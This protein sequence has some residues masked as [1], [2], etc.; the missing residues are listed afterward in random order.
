MIL[1]ILNATYPQ[2]TNVSFDIK[3][4]ATPLFNISLYKNESLILT[5]ITHLK[6]H[7]FSLDAG[8]YLLTVDYP[9]D[10][11][12][13]E[14]SK[15]ITF[16]VSKA[17]TKINLSQIA[18]TVYGSDININYTLS[19][20]GNVT[21]R[22]YKN[23]KLMTTKISNTSETLKI[24]DSAFYR[25]E[26]DY[27]GDANHMKASQYSNFTVAQASSAIVVDSYSNIT[28]LENFNIKVTLINGSSGSYQ[29]YKDNKVV[30]RGIISS[31]ISV[32]GLEVGD[33]SIV[34]NN[35]GNSNHESSSLTLPF[36]V[37]K[38]TPTITIP[39]ISNRVYGNTVPVSFSI[40]NNQNGEFNVS[41]Y[42]SNVLITSKLINST[43]CEF[44]SL[45]SGNYR[46]SVT[47]LGDDNYNPCTK[48]ASFNVL[49]ASSSVKIRLM[50]SLVYGFNSYASFKVVNG[51][52]TY[53]VVHAGSVIK[54]GSLSKPV[55]LSDLNAGTY[56]INAYN[57]GDANHLSSTDSFTFTLR[58]ATPKLTLNSIDDLN[59]LDN[60]TVS[61]T[62]DNNLNSPVNVT[63]IKDNVLIESRLING[64]ETTFNYLNAGDYVVK[65]TYP[66]DENHMDVTQSLN[67]AVDKSTSSVSLTGVSNITYG[68]V[69]K[70]NVDYTNSTSLN[71]ILISDKN[72]TGNASDVLEFNNLAGGDYIVNVFNNG[73]ENHRP[74]SCT[75]KFSVLKADS[76]FSVNLIPNM[77]WNEILNITYAISGRATGHV[78]LTLNDIERTY[79]LF[80]EISFNDL[81]SGQY[82]LTLTYSGD[83]N[84]TSA[85]QIT[86]FEIKPVVSYVF[87]NTDKKCEITSTGH[88]YTLIYNGKT[89][90]VNVYP[91][92]I[93]VNG[94]LYAGISNLMIDNYEMGLLV[95]IQA[96]IDDNYNGS[97]ASD[98]IRVNTYGVYQ[99]SQYDT[100][101]TLIL[102]SDASGSGVVS[103]NGI[104]YAFDI[105]GGVGG[106]NIAGLAD[107]VYTYTLTYYGDVKY[108]S[109][110]VHGSLTVYHP[111]VKVKP[112]LVAS[113][114]TYKASLK[115]KKY[116]VT[117]KGMS[118][119]KLT[120]KINKKTYK[121]KTNSK[122]KA[123]FKIRLKKEGSYKAKI[124]YNGDKYHESV[125]KTVRIIIKK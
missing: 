20:D 42:K 41:V 49:K 18:D 75:A 115:V 19:A 76:G 120:L 5:N 74:S 84:F 71:Y 118:K 107:G 93:F 12:Y 80:E 57:N 59:Y 15:N 34:L 66:G 33:Y 29:I 108:N 68:D 61:F 27:E 45:E 78:N 52:G 69:L 62:L 119:A 14:T 116:K 47:Y 72:I 77:N 70:I 13:L 96:V 30:K 95:K 50:S 2:K 121:A 125:S 31:S 100:Q 92:A 6:N 101:I 8:D 123:V 67:F 54:S 10:E 102:P 51:S 65:V 25:V 46:L 55:S 28:F 79:D 82:T 122:G 26:I 113:K 53:N 11:N 17:L 104:G 60:L 56:T 112:K 40:S 22:I 58:K 1:N 4:D 3:G 24:P 91:D 36:K 103:V 98:V 38:A 110:T 85:E 35:N 90:T 99:I 7:E 63:L 43:S 86:D 97:E 32:G 23:N 109:L 37:F 16:T 87:I 44:D 83:N 106:V 73:D 117:L 94:K 81:K 89:M 9:G 21:L 48:T 124:K 105:S 64:R 39:R 111:I 114:K 88:D